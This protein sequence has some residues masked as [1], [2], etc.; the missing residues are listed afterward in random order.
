MK[1]FYHRYKSVFVFLT[2][3]LLA[4]IAFLVQ[5]ELKANLKV[6]VEESHAHAHE[7]HEGERDIHNHHEEGDEGISTSVPLEQN[8]LVNYG[9]EVTTQM[10]IYGW[11]A[12]GEDPGTSCRPDPAVKRS[13]FYSASVI[14]DLRSR[15]VDVSWSQRLRHVP[16]NHDVELEGYFKTSNLKGSAFCRIVGSIGEGENSI[17]LIWETKDL[18]SDTTDWTPFESKIYL[19]PETTA[20]EVIVGIYGEGQAWFDDLSLTASEP[21]I[22]PVEINSNLLE[23]PS[24]SEGLKGWHYFSV[25][26][27]PKTSWGIAPVGLDSGNALWMRSEQ[28][29]SPQNYSGFYQVLNSLYHTS[30]R[31]VFSGWM[32]TKGLEGE[33]WLNLNFYGPNQR[34][35]VDSPIALSGNSEWQKIEVSYDI[36]ENATSVWARMIFYG[37]GEVFCDDLVL[38]I[39]P[40]AIG[41]SPAFKI[42]S[43]FR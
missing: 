1:S 35:I 11:E 2:L 37:K 40:W 42:P 6:S 27:T 24:F 3:L 34:A 10:D 14:S 13:G 5:W 12:S 41:C 15:G 38:E 21:E 20:A 36:P 9:F 31:I 18:P 19:P 17:L 22:K 29:A 8:L 7:H 32:R 43:V 25:M 30:G 4:I 33:A 23:N 26:D 39:V 28:S 16:A